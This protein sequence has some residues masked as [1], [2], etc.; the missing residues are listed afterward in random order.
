MKSCPEYEEM[1]VLDAHGELDPGARAALDM[2]LRTCGACQFER[3][4]LL[5]VLG[6]VRQNL[7]APALTEAQTQSLLR[8]VRKG[9][10][11][12]REASVGWRGFFAGRPLRLMPAMASLCVLVIAFFL[13]SLRG[14]DSPTR[15]QS[16]PDSKPWGELR[17][18][19]L[20]IIR[21]MDLLRDMDRVQRLV[22]ALDEPES[23]TPISRI[24][25]KPQ[26]NFPPEGR[27]HYA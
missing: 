16:E 10:A 19:D 14:P 20:E 23:G 25:G 24:P 1:V 5:G 4:R 27:G 15:T 11:G 9:L 2:H 22:Q 6:R 17:G 18:E 8:S 21:N 26:A 7:R 3:L 13:F 12:E